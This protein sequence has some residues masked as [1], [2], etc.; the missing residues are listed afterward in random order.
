MQALRNKKTGRLLVLDVQA[1]TYEE[2][3]V[4][5]YLTSIRKYL[6]L[7]DSEYNGTVF[8]T[9]EQGVIEDLLK[10]GKCT[11]PDIRIDFGWNKTKFELSDL[12]VVVLTGQPS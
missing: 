10:E 9:S 5:E 11:Y 8:V 7:R 12:E 4:S 6:E 1:H 3:G 2:F